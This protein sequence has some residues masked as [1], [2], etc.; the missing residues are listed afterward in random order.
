MDTKK[1]II[2]RINIF[3]FCTSEMRSQAACRPRVFFHI[4]SMCCWMAL[5]NIY[6]LCQALTYTDYKK[7]AYRT[8]NS[9]CFNRENK[10]S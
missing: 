10:T 4:A 5:C 7:Q 3:L 8:E 9:V 2:R 6:C 1:I